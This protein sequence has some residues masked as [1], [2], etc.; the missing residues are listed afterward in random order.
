MARQNKEQIHN[1]R[2]TLAD[3]MTHKQ[4]W[5]FKF[6]RATAFVSALSVI[7][8]LLTIFYCLFAFTPIKTFIPGYP[9]GNSKRAAIQNAI[10]IDSLESI[11]ARWDLYSENLRRV[12]EGEA[13]LKLDSLFRVQNSVPSIDKDVAASKDSLLRNEVKQTEMTP[14]PSDKQRALQIE[15]IHF[16]IPAKGTITAPFEKTRHPYIDITAPANTMVMSILEGTVI[17]AGWQ[18]DSGYT[19]IIQHPSDI[20]SVYKHNQ[21]LLKKVGDQIKAGTPIAAFGGSNDL[22]T[23]D[24]LR[25]ELWHNGDPEDPTKYINFPS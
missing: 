10:K 12:V 8:V 24:H 18:E 22:S 21:K 16:F 13:P 2:I 20:I 23:G 3:D 4:L 7:V 9:D 6:T 14:L 17:Y 11:I 25:F 15:G 1:F 19:I 5:V